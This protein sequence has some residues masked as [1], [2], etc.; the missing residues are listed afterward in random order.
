M[1]TPEKHHL[2]EHTVANQMIFS[3]RGPELF[4]PK[5]KFTEVAA[6]K[7]SIITELE[8]FADV[9]WAQIP[10]GGYQK[11]LSGYASQQVGSKTINLQSSQ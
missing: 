4:M 11:L 5:W 2:L 8:A 1:Q 6:C 3:S 9:A 10:Q 7:P